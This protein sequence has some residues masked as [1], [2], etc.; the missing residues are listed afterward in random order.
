MMAESLAGVHIG[1]MDFNHRQ[2]G[3]LDGVMQGHRG[4]GE[5]TRIEDSAQC[6]AVTVQPTIGVYL[7]YQL[8]FVVALKT[9]DLMT[10]CLGGELAQ[11]LHI[12]QRGM[13]V[14]LGF[15][16]AEQV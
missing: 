2:T 6:L 10:Q 3:A 7:V 8:A 5:C 11:V 16:R 15:T 14:L 13:A 9:F 1:N 12:G 4:V